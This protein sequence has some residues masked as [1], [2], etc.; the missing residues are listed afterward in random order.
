MNVIGS[1]K[2]FILK[3]DLLGG[4]FS[5]SELINSNV[6]IPR[7]VWATGAVIHA[8]TS[9]NCVQ[10]LGPILRARPLIKSQPKINVT[11]EHHSTRKAIKLSNTVRTKGKED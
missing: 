2:I 9:L 10:R 3:V 4:T 7:R 8:L 1:M 5:F 11:T 6:I